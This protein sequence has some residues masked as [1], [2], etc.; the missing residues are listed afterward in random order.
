VV[1]NVSFTTSLGYFEQRFHDVSPCAQSSHRFFFSHLSQVCGHRKGG[2]QRYVYN[3]FFPA[4]D[5]F[6]KTAWE[7]IELQAAAGRP[8]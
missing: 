4:S 3:F 5:L 1:F 2:S 7:S 6:A 8:C